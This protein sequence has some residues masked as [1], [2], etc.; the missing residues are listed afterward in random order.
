MVW[1]CNLEMGNRLC[2]ILYQFHL[3]FSSPLLA[4][5]SHQRGVSPCMP[6][7][8]PYVGSSHI[9]RR[10]SIREDPNRLEPGLCNLLVAQKIFPC[11]LDPG[12]H[13]HPCTSN[14]QC[15]GYGKAAASLV[16]KCVSCVCSASRARLCQILLLLP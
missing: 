16:L 8:K 7:L 4:V 10:S 1:G 9:E 2:M 6:D 11:R 12:Q 13:S 14:C 15:L 3:G 5:S